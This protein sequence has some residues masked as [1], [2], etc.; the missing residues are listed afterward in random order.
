MRHE[1]SVNS[2]SEVQGVTLLPY[3]KAR[4]SLTYESAKRILSHAN[5]WISSNQI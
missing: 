3:E 5:K 2:F 4:L 1:Y